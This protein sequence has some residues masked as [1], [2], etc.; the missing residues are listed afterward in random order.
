M[1]APQQCPT[2]PLRTRGR[3]EETRSRVAVQSAGCGPVHQPLRAESRC[4]SPAPTGR[5]IAS[6]GP[7]LLPAGRSAP[8]GPA[9]RKAGGVCPAA[10][11]PQSGRLPAGR[12]RNVLQTGSRSSGPSTEIGAP[13][14]VVSPRSTGRRR[15]TNR[16][17]STGRF[18]TRKVQALGFVR[19]PVWNRCSAR[20]RPPAPASLPEDSETGGLLQDNSLRSD[21]LPCRSNIPFVLY[22]G[23]DRAVAC[24]ACIGTGH[25]TE[26]D[27]E[28]T[29]PAT[30]KEGHRAY[31]RHDHPRKNGSYSLPATPNSGMPRRT[32]SRRGRGRKS[33]LR[34]S[35]PQTQ[36]S[37]CLPR[38]P[39]R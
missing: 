30:P 12:F 6:G 37:G 32:C 22:S 8:V 15:C 14:S 28:R 24:A 7:A 36:S 16:S 4:R 19:G 9:R 10:P 20:S 34:P 25:V 29:V 38:C 1:A 11:A 35:C 2:R 27:P 5:P 23:D 39:P 33:R 21:R 13:P 17:V 18:H 3:R 26:S 31:T